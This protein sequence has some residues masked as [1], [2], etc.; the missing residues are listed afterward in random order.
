MSLWEI[1]LWG[2]IF[3]AAIGFAGVVVSTLLLAKETYFIEKE[4][5]LHAERKNH[6]QVEA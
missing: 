5:F 3:M 6:H 4:E 2:G 1:G